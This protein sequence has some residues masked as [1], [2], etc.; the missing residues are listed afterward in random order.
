MS[1]KFALLFIL[2]ASAI[3]ISGCI[4]DKDNGNPLNTTDPGLVPKG[5]IPPGF[6]FLGS[7]NTSVN[8][9]GKSLN[10]DEEV[11]RNNNEEVYVQVI[12]NDNPDALI[13]E[14]MSM[15][16]KANYDPFEEVSFNGHKATKVK[17]YL[18]K[19]SNQIPYYAII[20][21]NGSSMNIVGSLPDAYAVLSLATATGR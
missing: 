16:S 9:N 7:H 15:Y 10:A 1:N 18:T 17:D 11:F 13:A 4:F 5:N 14:Y 8:I 20:W 3:F 21:T 19:N 6:T 2:L 12:K